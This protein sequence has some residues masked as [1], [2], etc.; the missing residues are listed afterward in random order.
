[1]V[2]VE[3]KIINDLNVD[4]ATSQSKHNKT[5]VDIKSSEV[6]SSDRRKPDATSHTGSKHVAVAQQ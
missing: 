4:S 5:A 2:I 6:S 3:L 1:M